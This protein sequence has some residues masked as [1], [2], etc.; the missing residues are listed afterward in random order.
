MAQDQELGVA[1]EVI[2]TKCEQA[3][4][5]AEHEEDESEGDPGILPTSAEAC[6]AAESE[7]WNPSPHPI[8][9]LGLDAVRVTRAPASAVAHDAP[10]GRAVTL[11]LRRGTARRD[12]HDRGV[13]LT[14]AAG[15]AGDRL[16]RSLEVLDGLLGGLVAFVLV[17]HWGIYVDFSKC[18]VVA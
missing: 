13:L 1:L 2:A 12:T 9:L 7:N 10:A 14:P 11:E 5:R 8:G 17:A 18:R 6:S 16:G 3:E 4:R 15:D